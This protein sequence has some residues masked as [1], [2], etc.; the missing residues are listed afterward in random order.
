[1]GYQAAKERKTEKYESAVKLL[2]E[3]EKNTKYALED[4]DIENMDPRR[5]YEYLYE[6][7]WREWNGLL[8]RWESSV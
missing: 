3:L 1:M 2:K 8:Q 5:L 7:W 4:E 6:E